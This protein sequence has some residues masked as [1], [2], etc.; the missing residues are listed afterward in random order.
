MKAI[1]KATD[2]LF[3]KSMEIECSIRKDVSASV[4]LVRVA[5]ANSRRIVHDLRLTFGEASL[6]L[7]SYGRTIATGKLTHNVF[8][9]GGHIE[10]KE[11]VKAA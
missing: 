6:E 10:A 8:A 11:C 4:E 7:I 5:N 2:L 1:I 3:N 9:G